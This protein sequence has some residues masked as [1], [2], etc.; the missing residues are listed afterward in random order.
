M[1]KSNFTANM[2]RFICSFIRC[3]FIR[4][5]NIKD[6]FGRHHTHLQGIELIDKF[7]DRP[8]NHV[9]VHD[10][11]NH[12]PWGNG[13]CQDLSGAVPN[14]ETCGNGHND[15]QNRKEDR[16]IPVGTDVRIPVFCID[17]FEFTHLLIFTSEILDH[18]HSRNMLL[19]ERIQVGNPQSNT[20]KG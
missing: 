8:E 5:Q 13:I 12:D 2:F 1:L 3:E 7:A 16:E 19:Q 11:G 4:I 17:C 6:A 20:L 10:K 15:F 18:I 14:Q 9:D